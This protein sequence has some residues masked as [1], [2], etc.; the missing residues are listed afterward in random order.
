MV[1]SELI[2]NIVVWLNSIGLVINTI[3]DIGCTPGAHSETI[4]SVSA[5][6]KTSPTLSTMDIISLTKYYP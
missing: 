3:G 6:G 1:E 5:A 4:T 2:Q